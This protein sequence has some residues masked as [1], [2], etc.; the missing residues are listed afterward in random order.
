MNAFFCGHEL[1]QFVT[2]TNLTLIL[3]KESVK[4]FSDLRPIS[5]NSFINKIISKVIHERIVTVL[6][7]LISQNQSRFVKGRNIAENILLAQEIIR[8]ISKRNNNVNMVV[9]LD[10]EKAYDREY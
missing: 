2:H 6:L 4:N 8:D 7:K 3:K 10:M 9:K 5:L 1:T